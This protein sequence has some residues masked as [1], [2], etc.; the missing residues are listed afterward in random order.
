MG[1]GAG[2]R[3]GGGIVK[4]LCQQSTDHTTFVTRGIVINFCH[5][6]H[7]SHYFCS[8]DVG[9]IPEQVCDHGESRIHLRYAYVSQRNVDDPPTTSIWKQ[10]SWEG[11]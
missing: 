8:E 11:S 6:I 2:G 1:G 4:D 3:G 7:R 9:R 5:R 10:G